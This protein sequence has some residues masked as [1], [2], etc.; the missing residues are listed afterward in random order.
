MKHKPLGVFP[1]GELL[2]AVTN[3]ADSVGLPVAARYRTDPAGV[4]VTELRPTSDP[5]TWTT[6]Q[7][8]AAVWIAAMH[9]EQRVA[10]VDAP[11]V[12]NITSTV[13]ELIRIWR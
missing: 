6:A 5:A 4:T 3:L 12:A 11:T 1:P 13:A 2:D 7:K 10:L 8:A 9:T